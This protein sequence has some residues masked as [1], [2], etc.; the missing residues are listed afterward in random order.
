VSL[1]RALGVLCVVLAL[2]AAGC[3]GGGD[4]GVDEWASTVCGA[5]EDWGTSLRTGSQELAPAMQN[6]RDLENVKEAYIG[7]LEESAQSSKELVDEVKSAGPPDTEEGQ[8]VQ[9]ALVSAFEKVQ[10]SFARAVDEAQELSTADG[11][12][13]RIGVGRLSGDV[14]KNLQAAGRFFTGIG[15]RSS[16]IEEAIEDDPNCGQFAN[17]G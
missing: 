15:E 2:V 6:T 8:A 7:F 3:G 14:E 13:F 12:S 4:D 16:E 9:D 5:L 10:A 1:L 17:A 11:D